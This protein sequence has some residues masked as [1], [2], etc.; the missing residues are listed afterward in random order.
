MLSSKSHLPYYNSIKVF[1]CYGLLIWNSLPLSVKHSSSLSSFKSNLKTHH[2]SSAYW[3]VVFFLLI[4]STNPLPVI[5]VCVCVCVRAW[6][7][8]CVRSCMCDE[9]NISTDTNRFITIT[10]KKHDHILSTIS[11]FQRFCSESTSHSRCCYGLA[12]EQP[13]ILDS[14]TVKQQKW[15]EKQKQVHIIYIYIYRQIYGPCLASSSRMK[16][17]FFCFWVC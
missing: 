1:Q 9:M 8:A 3:S 4:Y 10:Q 5:V 13:G 12:S 2:F 7:H 14:T 6:V 15:E 17:F 16:A 11:F